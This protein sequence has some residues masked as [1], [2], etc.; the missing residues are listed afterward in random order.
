VVQP[1]ICRSGDAFSL[2]THLIQS[3]DCCFGARTAKPT[4][5]ASVMAPAMT[6]FRA[7]R[8]APHSR[9]V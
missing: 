6:Y 3:C 4:I 1:P 2:F 9:L 7:D 8:I 5:A